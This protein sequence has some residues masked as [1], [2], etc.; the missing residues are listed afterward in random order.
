MKGKKTYLVMVASIIG[1]IVL[2]MEGSVEAGITAIL[3]A[4]GLGSL[5]AGVAKAGNGN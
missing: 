1:G 2:I 5:R 4:L 3:A